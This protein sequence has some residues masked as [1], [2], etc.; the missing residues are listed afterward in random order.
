MVDPLLV[1]DRRAA[2]ICR[3]LFGIDPVRETSVL[4]ERYHQLLE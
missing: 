2:L 3:S 1:A 4:R